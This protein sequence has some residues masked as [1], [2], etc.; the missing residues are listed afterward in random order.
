[1]IDE[2]NSGFYEDTAYTVV[3]GIIVSFKENLE[4]WAV[5]GFT[6]LGTES[7]RLCIILHHM[8]IQPP[9]KT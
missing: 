2:R 8:D 6:G 5:L 7:M 9:P 3:S 4:R 1:M